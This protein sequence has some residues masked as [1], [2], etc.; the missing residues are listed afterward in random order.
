MSSYCLGMCIPT[1]DLERVKQLINNGVS[2]MNY[3]FRNW[4]VLLNAN[5]SN[6][7]FKWVVFHRGNLIK[8]FPTK[9]KAIHFVNIEI[10]TNGAK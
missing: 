1:D 3:K 4:K 5:Q 9:Q 10:M 2:N 6:K 7:N 8:L